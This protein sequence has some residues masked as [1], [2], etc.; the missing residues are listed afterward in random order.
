MG[1]REKAR[2]GGGRGFWIEGRL[3]AEV[4]GEG[5][6]EGEDGELWDEGEERREKE[7]IV[8]GEELRAHHGE[9]LQERT[10]RKKA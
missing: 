2:V 7:G 4:R 1:W 8:K 10:K 9:P 3:W 6:R 5:G